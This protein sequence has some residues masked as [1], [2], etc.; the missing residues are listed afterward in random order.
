M[1]R[2][3]ARDLK[4][5]TRSKPSMTANE[6]C[7]LGFVTGMMFMCILDLVFRALIGV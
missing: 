2:R 5:P 4:P 7:A 6:S 3:M 1:E